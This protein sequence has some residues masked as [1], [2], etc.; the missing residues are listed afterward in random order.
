[1]GIKSPALEIKGSMI[2]FSFYNTIS[3]LNCHNK[4]TIK[5]SGLNKMNI[6]SFPFYLIGHR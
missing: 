6:F 4:E 1:M 5:Y 3:K 2:L